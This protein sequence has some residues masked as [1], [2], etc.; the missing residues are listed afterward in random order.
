LGT[1][2]GSCWR[3][4][5]RN[6]IVQWVGTGK[7]LDSVLSVP[8]DPDLDQLLENVSK[9]LRREHCLH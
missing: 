9:E 6:R 1:F 8:Y 7:M 4:T 2:A 3:R 5:A